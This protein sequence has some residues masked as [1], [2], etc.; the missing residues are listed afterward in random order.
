MYN[1]PYE[2]ERY[3]KQAME[4][5][6]Y[7]L[8]NLPPENMKAAL[9]AFINGLNQA[10][11][12]AKEY[13]GAGGS[14][15]VLAG[16]VLVEFFAY[17]SELLN[18]EKDKGA[19]GGEKAKQI[20]FKLSAAIEFLIITLNKLYELRYGSLRPDAFFGLRETTKETIEKYIELLTPL[21]NIFTQKTGV[22]VFNNTSYF[23]SYQKIYLIPDAV[24]K[25]MGPLRYEKQI[26]E[27]LSIAINRDEMAVAMEYLFASNEQSSTDEKAHDTEEKKNNIEEKNTPVKPVFPLTYSG[28]DFDTEETLDN[29]EKFDL[30]LK[31]AINRKLARTSSLQQSLFHLFTYPI[32]E[33]DPAEGAP[34][35]LVYQQ[36]QKEIL[37]NTDPAI[38]KHVVNGLV[39]EAV[40]SKHQ[41]S[42]DALLELENRVITANK[43][44]HR[45]QSLSQE[46]KIS[47]R[48]AF[49]SRTSNVQHACEAS[50]PLPSLIA[51]LEKK[52][53]ALLESKSSTISREESEKHAIIIRE[54][55]KYQRNSIDIHTLQI[56]ILSRFSEKQGKTLFQSVEEIL[57]IIKEIAELTALQPK[58]KSAGRKVF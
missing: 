57:A 7:L 41:F 30:Q 50:N 51:N 53:E 55:E 35:A 5:Q 47:V 2:Q 11:E 9:Y 6:A 13:P 28:L 4:N 22:N 38:L 52:V 58:A 33:F 49:F 18:F 19:F 39:E 45:L 23:S 3:N 17:C 32:G 44:L 42:P 56:N 54:V 25:N 14:T 29:A 10:L 26:E 43:E 48:D 27:S 34:I 24:R 40:N 12:Q 8:V 31:V 16:K 20:S 36:I 46:T 1:N 21:L 15:A 37:N